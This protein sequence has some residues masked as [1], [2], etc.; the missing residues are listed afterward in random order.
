[1]NKLLLIVLTAGVLVVEV[2]MIPVGRWR[3]SDDGGP[4]EE[5]VEHLAEQVTSLTAQLNS[6]N[7]DLS[8]LKSKTG[9]CAFL[10]DTSPTFCLSPRPTFHTC[11][12]LFE[13]KNPKNML[14]RSTVFNYNHC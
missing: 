11:I 13:K 10:T 12:F 3:R 9:K 5:V 2:E 7:T 14:G 6:V 8:A 4:L 1:M